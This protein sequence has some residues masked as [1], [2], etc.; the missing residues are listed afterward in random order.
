MSEGQLHVEA[1]WLAS[2]PCTPGHPSSTESAASM[3]DAS[4]QFLEVIATKDNLGTKVAIVPHHNN[5][6]GR[7]LVYMFNTHM[8]LACVHSMGGGILQGVCCRHGVYP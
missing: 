1:G 4:G 8:I 2:A 7:Y 6:P 5:W 3:Q